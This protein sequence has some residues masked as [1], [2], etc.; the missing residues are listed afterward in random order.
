[1]NLFLWLLWKNIYFNSIFLRIYIFKELAYS[2]FICNFRKF[3]CLCLI[4]VNW[5]NLILIWTLCVFT[6]FQ[7]WEVLLL[8][9]G[10]RNF[11]INPWK[12]TNKILISLNLLI[13]FTIFEIFKLNPKIFSFWF[14]KSNS[15]INYLLS[16]LM[17]IWNRSI[18]TKFCF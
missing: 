2:T 17:F 16:F 13:S 11:F 15:I 3:K 5:W 9:I 8:F 1:M 10:K 12:I 4:I 7:Y 14:W 6:R 18:L